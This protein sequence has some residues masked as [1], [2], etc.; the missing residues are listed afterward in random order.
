MDTLLGLIIGVGLSAACG[1]RL[2]V[3]FMVISIGSLSGHLTLAPDM[4]W[5][6]TYPALITF[7]FATLLEILVYFIPWVDDIMGALSIPVSIV[8]GTILTAAFVPEMSPFLRWTLAA[9]AGGMVAGTTETL[10]TGLRFA[11]TATTA[12]MGNGIL[13]IGELLS[14][15]LLSL[16]AILVPIIAFLLVIFFL[17]WSIQKGMGLIKGVRRK[18]CAPRPSDP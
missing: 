12:G 15:T 8:A 17:T 9:I 6:G 3:P 14:S 7:S 2:I 18:Q 10:T 11:S 13:S 16:L 5:I 1:F 4:A